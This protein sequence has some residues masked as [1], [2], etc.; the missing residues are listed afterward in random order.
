MT[1]ISGQVVTEATRAS[2]LSCAPSDMAS[3]RRGHTFEPNHGLTGPEDQFTGPKA[4]N[5]LANSDHLGVPHSLEVSSFFPANKQL[6]TAQESRL[7]IVVSPVRIR[8]S[9][10]HESP[11]NRALLSGRSGLWTGFWRGHFRRHVLFTSFSLRVVEG[12]VARVQSYDQNPRVL[13]RATEARE[14]RAARQLRI[15]QEIRRGSVAAAA[16]VA[17]QPVPATGRGR[18]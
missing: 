12:L 10:S 17:Q 15:C 13:I 16:V 8:V 2:T 9:P 7:K 6:L 3:Q 11:G 4:S 18:D 5:A 1:V 14:Q